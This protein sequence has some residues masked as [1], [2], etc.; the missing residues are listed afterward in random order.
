MAK[1]Y[2]EVSAVWREALQ[3]DVTAGSGFTVRADGN[4]SAGAS[5]M[6]LLLMG[7]AG[8]TGADVID[9]L[10]KKHQPVTGLEIQVHGKRAADHPMAYTDIQVKYIVSGHAVDPEAVRRSIELS[11]TKYCSAE[12]SLRGV[13]RISSTFEIRQ[14]EP[15]GA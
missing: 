7:V 9:I 10:R 15:A 13:A 4:A 1:G 11:E 3:F 5:P 2:K 14:V 6:E 12:A 8:C